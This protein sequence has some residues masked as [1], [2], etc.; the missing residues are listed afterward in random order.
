KCRCL[1]DKESTAATVV[2]HVRLFRNHPALRWKYRVHEQILPALR[3]LNH[4]VRWSDVVVNHVGYQDAGLRRRK[5]DRDLRLL[6]IENAEQP[7]DP[8]TLFNLGSVHHELGRLAEAIPLLQ[9]SLEL[10]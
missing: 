6:D 2:D 1:P 5:L 3:K 8:F 7:N 10:S 4:E 9:R